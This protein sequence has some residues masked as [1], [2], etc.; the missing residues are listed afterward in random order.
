MQ[1]PAKMHAMRLLMTIALS[2]SFGA[3]VE[4]QWWEVQTS[5]IDTNLRGVSATYVHGADGEP[6]PVVWVS[7]SNGVILQSE[8]EGRPSQRLPLYAGAHLTFP[9]TISF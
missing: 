1:S 7:G 3:S 8:D 6:V 4:A 2:L 9:R 5:G